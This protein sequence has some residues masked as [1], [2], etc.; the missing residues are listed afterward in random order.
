LAG[1]RRGDTRT[2]RPTKPLVK[3]TAGSSVFPSAS[4]RA[5]T[6][7]PEAKLRVGSALLGARQMWNCSSPSCR[8]GF[9]LE[10]LGFFQRGRR[11]HW[12]GKP[13]RGPLPCHHRSVSSSRDC[14]GWFPR[15]VFPVPGRKKKHLGTSQGAQLLGQHLPGVPA[16]ITQKRG[17]SWAEMSSRVTGQR[18]AG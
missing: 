11:C 16:T 18:W 9:L 12:V 2:P 10:R 15:C 5:P 7:S 8:E 14:E 13:Q 17:R 3:G 1:A 4:R 6:A